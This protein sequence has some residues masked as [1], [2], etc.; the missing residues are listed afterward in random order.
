MH[1]RMLSSIPGLY[2]LDACSTLLSPLAR[3][4]ATKKCLQMLPNIP[5]EKT[6]P[7]QGSVD[8][9]EGYLEGRDQEGSFASPR[10]TEETEFKIYITRAES[11]IL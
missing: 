6:G 3:I 5:G 10:M 8:Q 9:M 1:G 4:L 7:G 11:S 2:S